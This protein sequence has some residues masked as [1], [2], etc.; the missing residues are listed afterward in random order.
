MGVG[1]HEVAGVL[2]EDVLVRDDSRSLDLRGLLTGGG[3]SIALLFRDIVR[4]QQQR[5]D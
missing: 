3:G 2:L 5:D 4:G 1:E